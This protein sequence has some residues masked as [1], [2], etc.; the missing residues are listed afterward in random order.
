MYAHICSLFAAIV[1]LL[2]RCD[3]LVLREALGVRREDEQKAQK[4]MPLQPQHTWN[5]SEASIASIRGQ[6]KKQST[7]DVH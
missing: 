5:T 1:E 4:R 7:L 6:K 3:D 2:E